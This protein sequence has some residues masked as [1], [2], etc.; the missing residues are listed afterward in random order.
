MTVMII[1]LTLFVAFGVLALRY[2]KD[3]HEGMHSKEE[4][5]AAYGISWQER[6]DELRAQ[7]VLADELQVA[8]Q[9]RL[10]G[11]Q[12]D[13]LEVAAQR[14]LAGDLAQAALSAGQSMQ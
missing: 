12:T 3:S 13:K 11:N 6:A 4:E 5:F 2:G 8:R 1:I 7:E 9:R 10:V 14:H